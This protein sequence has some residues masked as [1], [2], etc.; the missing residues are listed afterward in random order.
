MNKTRNLSHAAFSALVAA[1]LSLPL[2]N[3]KVAAA[4]VVEAD[5]VVL[6]GNVLTLDPNKPVASA[7]A[8]KDGK[9]I[10]VGD[11]TTAKNFVGEHTQLVRLNDKVV[12][13]GLIDGH[14][15][16]GILS[17]FRN[18]SLLES[19]SPEP[20]VLLAT[21][22]QYAESH[23]DSTFIMAEYWRTA[24]FGIDGPHKS[25]IDAVVNDIPVAL[26]DDSGHSM[27]L[28]S[29]A[30]AF[31]GIDNNTP[32]P[33]P[34]LSTYVR[35]ENG[36][37]TGWVKEFATAELQERLLRPQHHQAF[38]DSLLATL[39]TL[40][41]QGVTRLY[42]GGNLGLHDDV[43]RTLYELDK[44]G[45][46]PLIYEGTFHIHLPEQ[47]KDAIPTMLRLREEYGSERLRFN[48]IKVHFDGVH[49]IRTSAILAP[50]EGDPTNTGETLLNQNELESFLVALHK[51]KLDLHMHSVGDRA[52]EIAL[53]AYE[54]VRKPDWHYPRM[55]L[56]HLEL[57]E[58]ADIPRFAQLGVMANYTPHW[59]GDLFQGGAETIGD[60][61]NHKMRAKAMFESG[62]TVSFSSDVVIPS[63][64]VRA[65]PFWGIEMSM[66]RQDVDEPENG[67]TMPPVDQ[68]LSL[69]Q[70][71]QA[72]TIN[73]ATQLHQENETGSIQSGKSADFV[74]ISEDFFNRNKKNIH[75]TTIYQTWLA[76]SPTFKGD[77]NEKNE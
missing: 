71:L 64:L 67:H 40:A 54:A 42:D 75:T 30:L 65:N 21:V 36:E 60:R 74:V 16:A 76:G 59:F 44:E 62:A 73:G 72:Y 27:W 2:L 34:G 69:I 33:A 20:K 38:K 70:A 68:K 51:A 24:D 12:L 18:T 25:M 56:A 46:L 31:L 47:V 39:N 77:N 29:K 53:N 9:F 55:T 41:S 48:T 4:S 32:D 8:I 6:D 50:F 66:T 61:N 19:P 11:N 45:K 3:L 58:P 7:V 57:V 43:Y 49:E 23:P 1:L 17:L 13:P 15:H 63:E 5:A 14:T 22:K 52:T 35:D 37:L 10:Y 28:N 26:L